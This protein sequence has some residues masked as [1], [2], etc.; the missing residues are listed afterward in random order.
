MLMETRKDNN[1][2]RLAELWMRQLFSEGY[3][4]CYY[5]GKYYGF[6]LP[7]QLQQLRDNG[8]VFCFDGTHH[9]YGDKVQL[10]MIVMKNNETGLGIPI[11]FLMTLST[12]E[13]IFKDF[14][15]SLVI[16]MWI[17][18]H[19]AYV[20]DV[21]VTDQGN[22]EIH[23]IHQ[24][25]PFA[26]IHFCAWHV[27]HAWERSITYEHLGIEGGSL[28]KEEKGHVK[29]QVCKELCAIMY[30]PSIEKANDLVNKLCFEHAH[31]PKILAYLDKNYLK[32]KKHETHFFKDWH[33]HCPDNVIYNMVKAVIPFFQHK[34]NHS[35]LNVG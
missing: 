35:H 17:E 2:D 6:S 25:F 18:F 24:A 8:K 3:Y 34:L 22:V 26:K 29:D 33:Q 20:P 21:V 12:E 10:F 4:T 5:P 1:E 32:D 27:L 7:W 15:S 13:S 23:A 19:I 28:L 30:E 14:F 31:H 11:A 9:V 16:Q